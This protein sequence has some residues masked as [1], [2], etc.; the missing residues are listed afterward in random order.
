M[1]SSTRLKLNAEVNVAVAK[2]LQQFTINRDEESIRN[3]LRQRSCGSEEVALAVSGLVSVNEAALQFLHPILRDYHHH[4]DRVTEVYASLNKPAL[5]TMMI[6]EYG[7]DIDAAVSGY[8]AAGLWMRVN[9][10]LNSGGNTASAIYAY[11]RAGHVL[12]AENLVGQN[13]TE[14]A[15]FLISGFEDGGC[16]DTEENALRLF[17]QV[18]NNRISKTLRLTLEK[19]HPDKAEHI[20]EKAAAIRQMR[21]DYQMSFELCLELFDQVKAIEANHQPSF[22]GRLFAEDSDTVRRKILDDVMVLM[23]SHAEGEWSEVSATPL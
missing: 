13:I 19:N 3:L 21:R 7:A 5:V 4:I 2:A 9:P 11:A 23:N 18:E 6:D 8:A 10:L 1:R 22:F 20:V 14:Y 17:S 16:F 15:S 12:Q